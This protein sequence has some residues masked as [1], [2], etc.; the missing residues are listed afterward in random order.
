[1]RKVI[2]TC[3]VGGYDVL[4]QPAV[5]DESFDY[6]CFTDDTA[7]KQDGVWQMRP[8]P[9][10][11]EDA[12]RLSRFVKLQPHKV[13]QDYGYSL[14]IDANLSIES[15]E[16][17]KAV[18]E[19]IAS[20]CLVA[21]VPHLE[22]DCIYEE[23]VACYRKGKIGFSEALKLKHKLEDESF[24]RHFGMMENCLILRKHNDAK[25][26]EIS[27]LWWKGYLEGSRRDQLSLMPVYRKTGFTPELLFGPGKN[28]RNVPFLK[29]NF[30]KMNLEE[31]SDSVRFFR[32]KMLALKRRWL[33]FA[34][35]FRVFLI[36]FVK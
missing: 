21:Q 35:S 25:V 20:G 16:L 30:H 33:V 23:I 34:R 19:K 4:Y 24:P 18:D 14:W 8:I 9:Y 5:V 1:M 15:A 11:D 29:Y 2:Y 6:I 22:R 31:Y 17:Y 12:T 7:A 3:V 26:V 13:L 10:S 28:S 27:D 32:K 36:P